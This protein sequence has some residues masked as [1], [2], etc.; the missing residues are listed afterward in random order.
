MK[1]I[2]IK[3]KNY[4][5]V[6][7]RIKEFRENE[8]YEGWAIETEI[9]EFAEIVLMKA[10][11]KNPEGK[12]IATGHAY[13]KE[14]S[15][16]I[17]KTSY[18]ENCETSAVGRALGNL[19][20]GIEESVASAEEVKNAIAQKDDP[21]DKRPWLTAKQHGIALKRIQVHDFKFDNAQFKDADEFIKSLQKEFRMKKDYLK[22]LKEVA[23][24]QEQFTEKQPELPIND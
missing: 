1:T 12:V 3:G 7:T 23:K 6:N 17:N 21:V 5:M 2:D 22:E 19:G 16:F 24:F 18:V 8:K 14:N 13:E 9:K 20:I 15:T 4:V 10:T 11:I